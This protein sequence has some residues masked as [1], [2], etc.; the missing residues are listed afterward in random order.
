MGQLCPLHRVMG[1]EQHGIRMC[2][3]HGLLDMMHWSEGKPMAV[4]HQCMDY[5]VR[6]ISITVCYILLGK[7]H[8]CMLAYVHHIVLHCIMHVACIY[9]GLIDAHWQ[10]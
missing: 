2:I 9:D 6:H 10:V 7:I 1:T 4:I 5:W 8:W 3:M